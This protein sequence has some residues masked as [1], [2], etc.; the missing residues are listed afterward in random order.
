MKILKA[1]TSH[2]KKQTFQI[3]KLSFIKYY[4]EHNTGI[5][6][7]IYNTGVMIDPIEI[8][9]REISKVP[10]FGALGVEYKE[11]DLVVLKGSQRITTA[12]KLGCTHIEGVIIN[13]KTES[14]KLQ[15]ELEPINE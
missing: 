8:E 11:K 12:I 3:S 7:D 2:P 10:R 4:L 1:K 15:D 9:K 13:D 14:E 5:I 6:D